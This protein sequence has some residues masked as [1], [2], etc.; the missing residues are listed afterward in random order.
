MNDIAL[1][2]R[3]GTFTLDISFSLADARVTALFGP[4]GAGKSTILAVVA[5]GSATVR[6]FS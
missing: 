5:K 6:Q 1:K 2:H 3:R 4:S